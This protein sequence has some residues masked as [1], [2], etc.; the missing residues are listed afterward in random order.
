MKKITGLML[1][2]MLSAMVCAQ[3]HI[4]RG[5]ST[6]TSNIL[7]TFDGKHVYKGNSTYTSNILYTF[8]GEHLYKGNSTYTS[9]IIRTVDGSVPAMLLMLLL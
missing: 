5:N 8:D 2:L 4:Y 1:M 7:Y 9:N 6:Y 3:S